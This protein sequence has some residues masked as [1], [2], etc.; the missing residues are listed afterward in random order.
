MH[1][2][3]VI[4]VRGELH[5]RQVAAAG[6]HDETSVRQ[7]GSEQFG[8]RRR[9]RDPVF[10]ALNYQQGHR[11][12]CSERWHLGLGDKARCLHEAGG[13]VARTVCWTKAKVSAEAAEP[14]SA[15][16]RSPKP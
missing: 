3:Q 12:P 2:D 5:L 11:Q 15:A 9:R 16:A 13:L 14:S 8:I 1:S 6:E 10:L 7:R 4:H